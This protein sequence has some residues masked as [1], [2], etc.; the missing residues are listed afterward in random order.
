[1]Q[2]YI[3]KLSIQ[4]MTVNFSRGSATKHLSHGA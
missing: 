1:M 2:H 4:K 3:V